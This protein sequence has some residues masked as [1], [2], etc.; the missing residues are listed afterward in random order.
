M[1][2]GD[3]GGSRGRG[4]RGVC[5]FFSSMTE[6]L[7][8]AQA[9]GHHLLTVDGTDV[10]KQTNADRIQMDSIHLDRVQTEVQTKRV[11]RDRQGPERHSRR[12][13][14]Q[15]LSSNPL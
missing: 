6:F 1:A 4:G 10:S 11:Q 13:I 3:H 14:A 9:L 5:M 2:V 8:A 15:T 12:S 7:T